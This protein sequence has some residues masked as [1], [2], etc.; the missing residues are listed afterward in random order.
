MTD[1]LR[2]DTIVALATPRGRAGLAVVRV[3]GREAAA[4]AGRCFRPSESRTQWPPESHRAVY[5]TFVEPTSGRAVD[6]V[7]VTFYRGPHSYTREDV[8]EIGTHGGPVVVEAAIAALRA[9]GARPAGPGEFTLRAF[10][11]GR[12]D[13][14]QAEA[15]ADLID[16]RTEAAHRHALQQLAGGLKQRLARMRENLTETLA[17]AE[18]WLDFPEEEIEPSSLEEIRTVC[19]ATAE[20]AREL[21]AGAARRRSCEGGIR[22]VLVGRPNVGKSSLFNSILGMERVLVSPTPGTTRD[23]VEATVDIDGYPFLI[24]DTAGLGEA[25]DELDAQGMRLSEAWMEQADVIVLIIEAPVGLTEA[26][27]QLLD[28]ARQHPGRVLICCNKSDAGQPAEL[29]EGVGVPVVQTTA[30]RA[31]GIAS[32]LAELRRIA[33]EDLDEAIQ[34]GAL[35]NARQAE[36]LE[37]LA[38]ALDRAREPLDAGGELELAAVDLHAALEA[39]GRVDG[40]GAEPDLLE[41]IF[42]RFCIGK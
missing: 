29:T 23:V 10:L 34:E 42:S 38:A 12:L 2:E 22:T 5:G 7:M 25:R 3:S 39:L 13:L 20:T 4:I 40:E 30:T 41:I 21:A 17:H 37:D 16:A 28:L 11:S 36:A 32:L 33:H 8:V 9:A 27:R 31:E 1:W 26:D 18:A 14:S 24:A 19:R 15:V 6:E 35:V